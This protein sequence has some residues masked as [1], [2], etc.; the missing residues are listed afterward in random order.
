MVKIRKHLVP[1]HIAKNYIYDG[2]NTKK[3]IVIHETDNTGKGAN[4][5][6]HSRLQYR[7]NDRDA[8]WHYQVDDKEIVQSFIDD[9][10]CWAAGNKY[11]NENGI[12]IEMCVNSDGDYKK[13][14]DNTVELVKSLMISYNIP[15]EN[16]I[17][18]N[19]ASG[20]N[21]PRNLRSGAKGVTWSQF[22]AKLDSKP[23]G[24]TNTST[25]DKKPTTPTKPVNKGDMKTTSIV[26][27]LKSIKQP[28]SIAA[29]RK[30]AKQYGIK[31]YVGT[32]AQNTKLLS[33]L[34]KGAPVSKPP[35]TNKPKTFKVGQTVK[36]KSSAGKYSRTNVTIPT[37]YK[38]KTMTVQQVAKDDVLL[39]E[40]YSWV[41]KTDI[42]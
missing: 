41:K 21:C 30:L 20:K 8:S 36:I 26:N 38:N 25:N 27:Y 39:K 18:H 17:Q 42:Q 35:V 29:R 7:G 33:L 10:Q 16:V 13:M 15:K 37:R 4:A 22:I 11:Y 14:L 31:F 3:Y 6:A 40:V 32:A 19:K 9:A 23:T 2:K 5:D 12:Q 24:N 28:S 1:D 34:R